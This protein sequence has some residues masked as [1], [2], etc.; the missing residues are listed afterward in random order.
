[1]ASTKDTNVY[2]EAVEVTENKGTEVDKIRNGALEGIQKRK[3]S[4][5]ILGCIKKWDINPHHNKR[6]TC[7]LGIL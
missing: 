4:E 1:M 5:R 7:T 3:H 6:K 2:L